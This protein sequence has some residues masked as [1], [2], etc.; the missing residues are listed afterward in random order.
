MPKRSYNRILDEHLHIL[1][2]QGNHEAYQRLKKRYY[3]HSLKLCRDIMS[4]HSKSGVTIAEL[5]AV[6]DDCFPIAVTKFDP[7][8]SSLFSFWRELTTQTIMDYL[9]DNAYTANGAEFSGAISLDQEFEDK[10]TISDY[11]SEKDDDYHKR[12]LIVEIRNAIAKNEKF[13]TRKEYA[14]LNLILDGYSIGE[15]EHSGLISRTNLYLTFKSAVRKLK[16]FVK[17]ANSNK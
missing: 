6:C 3:F 12:K 8:L 5:L 17:N 13:F 2:A 7:S 15:L 10:H 9:I 14:L 1:V 16:R 11:V 4:Q